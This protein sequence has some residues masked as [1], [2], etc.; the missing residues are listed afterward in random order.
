MTRA[1]LGPVLA[2]LLISTL[3]PAPATAATPPPTQRLLWNNP[4][5]KPHAISDALVRDIGGVPAGGSIDVATYW[6]ASARIADALVAAHQRGVR[7]RI[8]LDSSPRAYTPEATRIE[9]ELA[10]TPGD[11][12]SLTYDDRSTDTDEGIVH[13]KVFLLSAT[14]AER[15]VVVAGS[16]NATDN[17]DNNT[18]AA[19]WR[20]AG[21]RGLYDAFSAALAERE[22]RMTG[23][24]PARWYS[25]ARWAA[26]FLP[27]AHHAAEV[28]DP[29]ADPVVA[30]LRAVP[31]RR[32]SQVRILMYSMWGTRAGWIRN[33]LARIA[34]GGGRVILVA[35]PTVDPDIR[36]ALRTAGAQVVSG[37]Y[38]DG[39]FIHGKDMG[40]RYVKAG[41]TRHWTWIGSDN[42][43]S[44]GTTSGQAVLG[45]KGRAA[46]DQFL[47]Y[48]QP[49]ARRSDGVFGAACVP[50]PN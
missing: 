40:L 39:T 50:R 20:V 22:A 28:V 3:H 33:E 4:V 32:S 2:L 6:I 27:L 34:R 10:R 47:A 19:M 29:A 12:S 43:S 23:P 45:M 24:A 11:G 41:S 13:E 5:T 14:R 30:M 9:Q 37:C 21:R 7:L 49:L 48:F 25:G 35:G 17:S 15:W 31:A 16:W 18:Y 8:L 1:W 38:P 36:R 44:R 42:W 26:Y 46:H